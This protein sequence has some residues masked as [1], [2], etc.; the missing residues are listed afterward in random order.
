MLSHQLCPNDFTCHLY[1]SIVDQPIQLTTCNRLVCMECL[2]ASM[3]EKGFCCPCCSSDHL[4]DLNTMVRPSP[5]VM[6]VLDLQVICKKCMQQIA[7]GTC[8]LTNYIIIN[9]YTLNPVSNNSKLPATC[10]ELPSRRLQWSW[11]TT[12][13]D[14]RRGPG[15]VSRCSSDSSGD[16]ADTNLVHR[17]ESHGV[18]EIKTGRQAC[19]YSSCELYKLYTSSTFKKLLVATHFRESLKTLGGF[20]RSFKGD[21]PNPHRW[22]KQAPI[23]DQW[24]SRYSLASGGDQGLYLHWAWADPFWAA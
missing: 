5:V 20:Q 6:N 13:L 2:C 4:H 3:R 1:F 11:F 18:L 15:Q 14:H 24:R 7:A 23:S 22:A 17:Q 8:I 16:E 10:G 19:S 21:R 12:H 9:W